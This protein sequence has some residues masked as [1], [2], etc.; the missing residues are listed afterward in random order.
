VSVHQSPRRAG[1]LER[2]FT[3]PLGAALQTD[4]TTA[5]AA[6]TIDEAMSRHLL[7]TRHTTAPVLDGNRYVGIVRLEDLSAVPREQWSTI[8]LGDA[9][10]DD[11]PTARPSWTVEETVRAMDAS[12]RD[13]LGVVD[14]GG[15]FV[16]IVTLAD[17][18]RLDEILGT[19]EQ[20][21]R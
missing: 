5:S 4:V 6:L 3:L 12:D 8:S 19:T 15:R 17:L 1:H 16:G 9:V 2:R 21:E 7:M 10:P 11:Q 13:V 18:V 20:P 14:D